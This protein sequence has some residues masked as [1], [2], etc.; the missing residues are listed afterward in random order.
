VRLEALLRLPQPAE[1]PPPPSP[2]AFVLGLTVAEVTRLGNWVCRTA[3]AGLETLRRSLSSDLRVSYNV[4]PREITGEDWADGVIGCIESANL[5]PLHVTLELTEGEACTSAAATAAMRRLS[6]V[7]V[8]ISLDG[9]GADLNSLGLLQRLPVAEFK[10]DRDFV[11]GL[12]RTSTNSAILRGLV[13]VAHELA[14]TVVAEGIDSEEQLDLL[15][16]LGVDHGQGYLLGR[17]VELSAAADLIADGDPDAAA[18]DLIRL[19][20]LGGATPA[21]IAAALNSQGYRGPKGRRW[22]RESVARVTKQFR[23]P[24]TGE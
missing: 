12:S 18:V 14:I 3:L 5:R 23:T 22:H 16:D 24:R 8:G 19:M 21:T 11:R 6:S 13:G 9:V 7:G 17:P 2:R 15:R 1:G 4:D 20:F 10:V